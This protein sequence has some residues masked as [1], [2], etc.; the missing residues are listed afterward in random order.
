MK[1]WRVY[2]F[3]Y[4]YGEYNYIDV[5]NLDGLHLEPYQNCIGVEQL[6]VD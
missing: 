1:K 3:D 4:Y 5:D 2:Y 6:E